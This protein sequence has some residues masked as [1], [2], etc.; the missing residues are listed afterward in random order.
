[1]LFG[2]ALDPTGRANHPKLASARPH[3]NQMGT[4]LA[5]DKPVWR[6]RYNETSITGHTRWPH[7]S[8]TSSGRARRLPVYGR[9][10][11][12]RLPHRPRTCEP[13]RRPDVAAT[14]PDRC[15]PG[16]P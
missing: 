2:N 11:Q 7:H 16:D 13:D 14:A 15:G 1:M 10:D 4:V 5:K 12:L 8:R 3:A 9:G 6:S